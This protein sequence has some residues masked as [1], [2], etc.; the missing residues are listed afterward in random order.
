MGIVV[1]LTVSDGPSAGQMVFAMPPLLIGRSP[2]ADLCLDDPRVSQSHAR[3]VAE[4]GAAVLLD[5][6]GRTFVNGQRVSRA[7]LRDHDR[8]TVGGTDVQ[9]SLQGARP[10]PAEPP[11]APAETARPTTALTSLPLV[12]PVKVPGAEF[13]LYHLGDPSLE[14]ARRTGPDF[15]LPVAADA[16]WRFGA[17]PTFRPSHPA[18]VLYAVVDGAQKLE[19]AFAA[20]LAGYDP[21]SLFVGKQAPQLGGVAPYFFAVPAGAPYFAA[22][23]E[24]VGGNAGILIDSPA[25]PATL[26]T[27]LRGVFVVQDETGQEYFFRYYDPRVLRKYLP[28]CTAQELAEFFGPVRT[29]ICDNE[30]GDGYLAYSRGP[31]GLL[32]ETLGMLAVAAPT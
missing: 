20:K 19:L 24:S 5:M 15:V 23:A 7:V 4:E 8:I 32:Q 11:A 30:T 16:G 31:E 21:V 27:H 1:T 9:V 6:V 25:D 13:G 12:D 29:W 3:V 17:W 26:F 18:G 14:P 28:T 10:A 2:E 22:W